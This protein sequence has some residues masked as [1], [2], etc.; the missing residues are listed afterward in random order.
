M[1]IQY[2]KLTT[3]SNKYV[4]FWGGIFSNW[5]PCIFE[6]D[7]FK[8]SSSEQCFMALK[9]KYFGDEEIYEAIL[10]CG[11][12][13]KEAK[14]LGRKVKNFDSAKWDEVKEQMMYDACYAKFSQNEDLKKFMLDP[15]FDGKHFVEG[16]PYDNVWGS[17]IHWADD[18]A[19]DEKAWTGL[20]LLGKTLDKVKENLK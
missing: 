17:G 1:K 7:G 16:S 9:A 8:W 4:V 12:N 6:Y 2:Y 18:F 14:K 20:N 13:P 10:A 11:D 5:Y 19:H 3:V 15:M